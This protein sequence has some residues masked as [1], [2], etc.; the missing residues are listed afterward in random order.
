[1]GGKTRPAH[2]RTVRERHAG[3]DS[4]RSAVP[5]PPNAVSVLHDSRAERRSGNLLSLALANV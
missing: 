4:G 2:V 5:D 1:L 3:S